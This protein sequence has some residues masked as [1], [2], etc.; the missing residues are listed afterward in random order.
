MHDSKHYVGKLAITLDDGGNLG[1]VKDVYLDSGLGA[2]TGIFLGQ[3]GLLWRKARLVRSSE[4][5]LIGKDAL[6][7]ATAAS[8][9]NGGDVKESETWV[10]WGDLVGR[11]L[12]STLDAKVARIKELILDEAGYVKGFQLERVTV[13]GPLADKN[14]IRRSA[15]LDIGDKDRPMVVDLNR[16]AQQD[17][18]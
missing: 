16:L 5:T 18:K 12:I 14:E 8:L 6:L 7:I 17:K 3:E 15:I 4:I 10:L 2:V 11:Q 13:E 9:E 1:E